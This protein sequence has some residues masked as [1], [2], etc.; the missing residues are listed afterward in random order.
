MQQRFWLTAAWEG[1]EGR[2]I[3]DWGREEQRAMHRREREYAGGEGIDV[4]AALHCTLFTSHELLT[5]GDVIPHI[6][7]VEEVEKKSRHRSKEKEW[8][9]RASCRW[10]WTQ[11][12]R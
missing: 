10:G 2:E 5:I 6:A 11:V 7:D 3:K 1:A 4:V 12:G 8:G 9:K